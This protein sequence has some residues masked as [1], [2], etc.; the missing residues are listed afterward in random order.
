MRDITLGQ[1]AHRESVVHGLDP[2]TKV[3]S[4]LF[5]LTLILLIRRIEVLVLLCI[6]AA[7]L[8]RISRLDVRL[9]LRN[10]KP[11]VF[12]FTLTLL[13]HGFFTKG[14]TLFH[15]PL[16][17]ISLSQEGLYQGFFYCIRIALLVAFASL[18]TLSTSPMSI[19]DAIERFL[20]PF[21]RLGVPAHEIALM[22]TISIRFIPILIDEA[23]RIKKAQVSRGA[24]FHGNPVQR[25]HSLIPLI[26]PL[27]LS[28]FRRANDLALAMDARC[29]RGSEGRTNYHELRFHRVDALAFCFV[30]ICCCAFFFTGRLNAHTFG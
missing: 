24:R 17:G 6:F 12:L 28:S 14:Q 22:M 27:F 5:F 9:A 29:Y 2:R 10:L 21:R 18:L 25:I 26:I 7:F 8:Y 11:F 19:A 20:K 30:I 16:I 3:I 13:L 4:G 15:V 23:E 1:Y